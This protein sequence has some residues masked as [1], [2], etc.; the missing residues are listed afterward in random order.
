MKI[1]LLAVAVLTNALLMQYQRVTSM[2]LILTFAL[3]VVLVQTYARSKQYIQNKTRLDRLCAGS[4]TL[5]SP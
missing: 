3:T 4:E 2:L 5:K 1:A